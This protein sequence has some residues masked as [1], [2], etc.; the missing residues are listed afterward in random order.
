MQFLFSLLFLST[1]IYRHSRG[2]CEELPGVLGF[3]IDSETRLNDLEGKRK[4]HKAPRRFGPARVCTHSSHFSWFAADVKRSSSVRVCTYT[5]VLPFACIIF[6]SSHALSSSSRVLWSRRAHL[7][8]APT[9]I[10]L[11]HSF[12]N[13]HRRWKLNAII[14]R[15]K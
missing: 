15:L 2:Q 14:F 9:S 13:R 8:L 5:D 6:S 1:R 4:K 3:L 12:F 11:S 7:I 10:R